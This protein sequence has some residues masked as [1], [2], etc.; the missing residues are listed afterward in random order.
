M[1]AVGSSSCKGV[2][3]MSSSQATIMNIGVFRWLRGLLDQM[4]SADTAVLD[5]LDIRMKEA[6]SQLVDE[7]AR[8]AITAG[9]VAFGLQSYETYYN[10][11]W[12]SVGIQA[13]TWALMACLMFLSWSAWGKQTPIVTL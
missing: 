5:S 2:G 7:G 10:F 4:T 12:K 1:D 8:K 6:R 9:V 3:L 11:G 13:I